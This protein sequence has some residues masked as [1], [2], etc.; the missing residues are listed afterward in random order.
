[1]LPPWEFPLE[2]ELAWGLLA[3]RLLG[4]RL[5]QHRPWVRLEH[6]LWELCWAQ[7]C[8]YS[9]DWR[10]W[11]LAPHCCC[12]CCQILEVQMIPASRCCHQ[13]V[14]GLRAS[15]LPSRF[16]RKH[17]KIALNFIAGAK[18]A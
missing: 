16:N 12:R 15:Q 17:Y 8:S 11:A 18:L 1:M 9:E 7:L 13:E 14:L 3:S 6:C 4:W 5:A 10:C 2:L